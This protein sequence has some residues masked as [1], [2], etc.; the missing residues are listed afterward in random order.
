MENR[1]D[2]GFSSDLDDRLILALREDIGPGD[3]TTRAVVPSERESRARVVARE[4]FVLSG[5]C[6]FRRVFHLIDPE[7]DIEEPYAD[8]DAVPRDAEVFR[9]QGRT[10]SILTGERLALNLVQRLSGVATATRLMVDAVSGTGC[11]ILD[12]RKTTP[13]WRDL[14]K[15]AVRHGGGWNHRFGLFDGVLIKDNHVAAAGGVREAVKRARSHA[16]HTLKIEVE[17]DTLLQLDE[18]L[19]AGADVIL[20]D[21]FAVEDLRRAVRRAGG[22]ALLEASGGITVGTVRAVAETGVDFISSG[23]LTHSP[24]AVDLSLEMLR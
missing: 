6:V 16:P 15:E 20:L 3:V 2:A 5:S 21:N 9:I 22:R 17:V 18:A 11:R 12:T 14:E 23:A 7:L 13:L 1:G 19:D 10:A 4:P 24:R 8:G